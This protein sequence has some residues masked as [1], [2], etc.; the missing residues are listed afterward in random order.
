MKIFSDYRMKI[1]MSCLLMI[2]VSILLAPWITPYDPLEINIQQA[3]LPPSLHHLFGLDENGADVLSQVLHG[4]RISLGIA[5][6]VVLINLLIG[7]TIGSISAWMGS[8]VDQIFM[9][10]VELLS[11]FPRFLLALAILAMLGT[12]IYHLILVLCISGW[13]GFARLV[14][15]EILHL[16]NEDYV[17]GAM[18]YGANSVRI[19]VRHIW[20]NLLGVLLVQIFFSLIGAIISEAGLSFL[21]L[22]LPP[23]I[24]SWGRLLN[25]GRQ[26][27][28]EAP[29]LSLLPGLTLLIVI[30]GFQCCAD[31]LKD[32]F[33]PQT[34]QRLI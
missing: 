4:A 20:P 25:S 16:K 1:G 26:V 5:F 12:S 19:I 32:H 2:M 6:I 3:L 13:T 23:E 30:L 10:I 17:L 14:R 22:G 33:N 24:P 7:L 27:L 21:G 34:K 9:R 15:A 11:A 8:V 18:S 28:M 29:H 31:A